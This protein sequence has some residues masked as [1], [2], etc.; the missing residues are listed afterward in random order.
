ML[1]K[2]GDV[3]VWPRDLRSSD[4]VGAARTFNQT[5]REYVR[6]GEATG[7]TKLC[8]FE[9]IFSPAALAMDG[10]YTI[11]KAFAQETVF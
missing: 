5:I 4:V 10:F 1:A 9:S 8:V 2:L 11:P 7:A 3:V 6:A